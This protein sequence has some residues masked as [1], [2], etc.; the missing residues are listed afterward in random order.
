MTCTR[1]IVR[2]FGGKW[3]LGVQDVYKPTQQQENAM[4]LNLKRVVEARGL[5]P[6]TP[7]LQR[8]DNSD[9]REATKQVEI[10]PSRRASARFAHSVPNL[11]CGTRQVDGGAV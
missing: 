10:S 8:T 9:S 7:C 4:K 6:L 2:H 11:V 3:N 5:E 1:P